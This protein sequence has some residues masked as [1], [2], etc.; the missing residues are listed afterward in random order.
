[1][2]KFVLNDGVEIPTLGFGTYKILSD[3]TA[4]RAVSQALSIGYRLVDTAAL[5]MNESE[6]GKA[7]RDS[8]IARDEIFVTSKVWLQDNGYARTRAAIDDSLRRL[9][10]DYMDL[11]LVHQPYGD[12]QSTWKAMEEAKAAGKIRSIGVSN[13]TARMWKEHYPGFDVKPSVNQVEFNPYSQQRDIRR[14]MSEAGCVLQAWSPL[15]RADADLMSEPAISEIAEKHGK[16][17]AQTILG[18]IIHEGV[19]AL[20]KSSHSDRIRENFDVFDFSLDDDDIDAMRKLDKGHPVRD[21]DAPGV[22]Q[23]LLSKYDI[24]SK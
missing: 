17:I 5:Y 6:I 23:Y 21:P 18:F 9:D 22:A 13:M 14:I 2:R 20:V 4:Y 11:Y 10:M 3:G 24:Y 16:T 7:V 8:G 1:M 12:V 19:I 15:A